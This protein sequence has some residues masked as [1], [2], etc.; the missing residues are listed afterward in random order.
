MYKVDYFPNNVLMLCLH[1]DEGGD[2]FLY[3]KFE[4]FEDMHRWDM[5][6]FVN[7]W[8]MRALG[9]SELFASHGVFN[10]AAGTKGRGSKGRGSKGRGSKEDENSEVE[11]YKG[12]RFK[13]RD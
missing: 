6:V 9:G 4:G 10:G 2:R 13:L 12:D 5:G 8:I 3:V 7:Y 11:E 1:Q